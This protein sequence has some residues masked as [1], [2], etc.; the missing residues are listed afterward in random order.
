[1]VL[2]RRFL[3]LSLF[4]FWFGGLSF[5]GAVVVLVGRRL[6]G[7]QQSL[8][9]REVTWLM[10]WL[11]VAVLAFLAWD[12]FPAARRTRGRMLSWLGLTACLPPLWVLFGLLADRM[13]RPAVHSSDFYGL[14]RWYL[15]VVTVQWSFAVLLAWQSLK[16][17]REEDRREVLAGLDLSQGAKKCPADDILG[18][19]QSPKL[20]VSR[21]I[22]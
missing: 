15:V 16:A 3:V 7:S 4:T 20:P 12:I 21:T 8:V 11:A 13:D 17:W 14:H 5:Y 6:L 22:E 1:M 9:T 18:V 19:A 10:N 2:F